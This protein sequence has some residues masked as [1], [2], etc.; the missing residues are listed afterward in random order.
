M[1]NQDR[2]HSDVVSL[3]AVGAESIA[4]VVVSALEDQCLY[5]CNSAEVIGVM[6]E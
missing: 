4:S 5:Y 1:L 2:A 3:D 6:L